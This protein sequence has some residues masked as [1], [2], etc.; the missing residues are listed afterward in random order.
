[1]KLEVIAYTDLVSRSA[2]H[3]HARLQ[4]ALLETGIV[5]IGEVPDFEKRSLAYVH[6]ARAFSALPLENRQRYAPSRDKGETEGYELGAEWF[7]GEDNQWK[8]D[9]RKASYYASVPERATNKWPGEVD[10]KTPYLAL[11]EMIYQTGLR[12]LEAT[13]LDARVGLPHERLRGV[14]RMLHYHRSEEGLAVS[15]AERDTGSGTFSDQ[16]RNPDWCGA[17]FDHGVFTG[18]MPAWYFRDAEEVEE[19]EEAGLHVIPAG[20]VH[21]EKVHLKDKSIMLFQT[22]EFGQL[23]SNDYIRATKHKVTKAAGN[24]ERFAFA[25]F[26]SAEDNVVITSTSE[27]TADARYA[28]YQSETGSLSYRDWER[29]SLDRYRAR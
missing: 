5:G 10:L 16:Q 19:P 21:F 17:H 9:D 12:V 3:A 13:G 4:Q 1:M 6:A 23:A 2:H 8:I 7:K 18:L 20:A 14:G 11:G 24:I 26:F 29:A 22:G 27:L 25:L 28:D 15:A